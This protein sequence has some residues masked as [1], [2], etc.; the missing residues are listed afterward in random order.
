MHRRNVE[1]GVM[2][3]ISSQ[4]KAYRIGENM[5]RGKNI[6]NKKSDLSSAKSGAGNGVIE[7]MA[8]QQ[9]ANMANAHAAWLAAAWRAAEKPYEIKQK[10]SARHGAKRQRGGSDAASWLSEITYQ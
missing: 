5:F 1:R 3:M 8:Y 9:S 6:K 10:P 7:E 2:A 4:L